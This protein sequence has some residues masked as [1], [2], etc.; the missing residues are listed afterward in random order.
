MSTH[1]LI[2]L[3][4]GSGGI[5]TAIRAARH[6]A[7]VALLEPSLIGGT[8]VNVGCVPKKAMWLAAELAQAGR[9]AATL[10]FAG[11]LGRLDWPA[12]IARRQR[13][14]E[15]IHAGYRQRIDELG[16][17]M[18]A[19]AGRFETAQRIVADGRV[20]EAP[21][22]VVATGS[23]PLRPRFAANLGID[24]DGFFA[25]D[26]CPR[27]AA[28]V[29][30]GYVAVEL[31]GLLHALGAEVDLLVRGDRL[32]AHF[33]EE[34]ARRLTGLYDTAGLRVRAGFDTA[35]AEETADGL[36]VRAADGREVTADTLIWAVGRRPDTRALDLQAA[37][38]TCDAQGHIVVDAWQRTSAAGVHAVGDVTA[39]PALTPVAIAAGRALADRLFGGQPE[40]RLDAADVPT[41]I[42]SHPPLGSVGLGEA[43]ARERYGDAAV[44]VYSTAFRPMLTALADGQARSFIK[45]VCVGEEERIAG[46]HVLG[47]GADELLQ[48]F[49][50][51]VKMGARKADFDAT[52]AIHPTSAE[53]VVLIE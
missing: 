18:I 25:L 35:A 45:L 15:A 1:D 43:E 42:F 7:R 37:G 52:M 44:K 3:G 30:S 38:V 5:A 46:L 28:I 40:R 23:R 2:V 11:S 33:D 51:A 13:Y 4:G 27:R 36:R 34:I 9:L 17:E 50:V 47:L 29:G 19:A 24:S 20:L 12:F 39:A 8:C 49:A 32:L 31:A 22:I 16:I 10:G 41:V 14:I 53:E 26:A 21:Q 48:G 6:G